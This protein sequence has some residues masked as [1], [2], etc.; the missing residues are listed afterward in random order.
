MDTKQT[1]PL[2]EMTRRELVT[3]VRALKMRPAEQRF[4]EASEAALAELRR[5]E[6]VQEREAHAATLTY[7]TSKVL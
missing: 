4:D 6:R 3:H 1:K 5:P 7:Y 2:K